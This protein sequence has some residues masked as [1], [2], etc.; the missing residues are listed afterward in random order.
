M[1]D[2]TDANNPITVSSTE[3]NFSGQEY[4][5]PSA[6]ESEPLTRKHFLKY[7]IAV[8]AIIAV[9]GIIAYSYFHASLAPITTTITATT[10]KIT[11]TIPKTTSSIVP[12]VTTTIIPNQTNATGKIIFGRILNSTNVLN[13]IAFASDYN[14]STDTYPYSD[15]N[16]SYYVYSRLYA[17][18]ALYH[19]MSYNLPR[20]P[21]IYAPLD[22][23]TKNSTY[24]TAIEINIMKFNDSN[25][26][27]YTYKFYYYPVNGTGY[28]YFSKN[29]TLIYSSV[30][31]NNAN[32]TIK[33]EA[34]Y[35]T[36]IIG[37]AASLNGSTML[38]GMVISSGLSGKLFRNYDQYEVSVPP[39]KNYII[40]LNAFF[41]AGKVNES[42]V[43]NLAYKLYLKLK[44]NYGL[45]Q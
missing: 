23:L 25:S 34:Y 15:K 41:P 14:T 31:V 11:T 24:P 6:P 40:V 35:N 20:N 8:M 30:D 45:L 10:S 7:T 44:S 13:G 3:N 42:Y 39:Y 21:A 28:F 29:A 38:N 36:S 43:N 26:A 1:N 32:S 2:E 16:I 37:S 27:N 9:L 19:I 12:S 18:G 33:N 17:V 22:N 4:V 5:P